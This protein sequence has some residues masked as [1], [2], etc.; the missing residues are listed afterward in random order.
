M[1][2]CM[3]SLLLLLSTAIFSNGETPPSAPEQMAAVQGA[4]I[5][6]QVVIK[7]K[8]PMPNG[9][10]LL[11]N[12]QMGPPPSLGKYWRVPDLIIPL[13]SEGRFSLEVAEGTYY[14]QVA[15]KN[16]DA[17]IGPAKEREYLYFHSDSA[18][19]PRPLVATAGAKLNLGIVTAALWT[20]DMVQRDKGI[21]S[22]EGVVVDMDGK[23]VEKAVVFAYLSPEATGRPSFV[24]ER[25]DK[26][27]TFQLRFH[28]GGT[29]YLKVRSVFGGGTPQTGE[30]LNVTSDFVATVVSPK[31]DQ[32]LQGVTLKVK[33]FTK[34]GDAAGS[35]EKRDWKKL[36]P[37]PQ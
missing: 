11:Y 27:G 3:L 8:T 5:S 4:T 35:E 17:E 25:T 31:K 32:R 9:I 18:G 19:N 15:Q 7:D 1:K 36:T 6:G 20:P 37:Q 24:S 33:L 10:V 26:K 16:P 12:K 2:T 22:V 23:P 21:T 28:D 30:F 34:P 13:D 29:Y 14:L